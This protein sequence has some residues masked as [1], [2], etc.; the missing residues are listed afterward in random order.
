M[1]GGHR[2]NRSGY[3]E[4]DISA[5]TWSKTS[6]F[7]NLAIASFENRDLWSM[8]IG[9]AFV[10]SYLKN[11]NIVMRMGPA[12]AKLLVEMDSSY[13]EFVDEDGCIY[14]SLIKALYGLAESANLWYENI[15]SALMEINFKPS[16]ED[17]ATFLRTK[18][19][20]TTTIGLYVD[21]LLGMD[22]GGDSSKEVLNHLLG[23]YEKVEHHALNDEKTL[24]YLGM[25]IRKDGKAIVVHQ[26]GYI[27]QLKAK[28]S[29]LVM[30]D[31]YP[32]SPSSNVTLE[33]REGLP[34]DVTDY[35]AQLMSLSFLAQTSRAD[36]LMTV[37]YL[38]NRQVTPNEHDQSALDRLTQYVF[39]TIGLK[40]RIAANDTII[41][42][43]C[44][45]AFGVHSD[46]KSHSGYIISLGGT[47]VKAS[48]KKQSSMTQS[49][50]EAELICLNEI[51]NELLWMR[52]IL[53]EQ[54]YVQPPTVVEQDNLSSIQLAKFGRPGTKRTRHYIAIKKQIVLEHVPTNEMVPDTLTKP[55]T[56]SQF[57]KHRNGM[58]LIDDSILACS[59]FVWVDIAQ[60]GVLN[61]YEMDF[62]RE[63]K[64]HNST[65]QILG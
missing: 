16:K 64:V 26:A 7:T 29:H 62:C 35:K 27:E 52:R 20:I 45:A 41:R 42:G 65:R 54:G 2:Q 49:S 21:D 24:N 60:R 18:G 6:C 34:V 3:D 46:K 56:G 48:S 53:A 25:E 11:T 31:G 15:S 19:K 32:T 33:H 17:P 40:F 44:D 36:L 43:S 55:L 9:S 63:E 5:P 47:L 14:V 23:K 38:S 28:Y 59:T 13:E 12:I 8:D 1:E 61:F 57:L 4:S 50:T 10:N 37:S 30:P 22:L 51:K 39:G 58:Q